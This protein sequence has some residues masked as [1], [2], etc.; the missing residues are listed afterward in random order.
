MQTG[1]SRDSVSRIGSAHPGQAVLLRREPF[2]NGRYSPFA[3]FVDTDQGRGADLGSC[4]PTAPLISL[5]AERGT[6]FI[7][8]VYAEEG[9]GGSGRKEPLLVKDIMYTHIECVFADAPVLE[10]VRKMRGPFVSAL[11]VWENGRLVGIVTD[12]DICC[13]AVGGGRD[14]ASLTVREIMSSEA[15]SCFVDDDCLDAAALMKA[16]GLRRLVALDRNRNVAGIVAV[17]DLARCSADLA[18]TVLEAVASP[19]RRVTGVMM[20]VGEIM[21][22]EVQTVDPDLPLSACAQRMETASIGALPVVKDGR[23]VGLITDRDICCRGV[24]DVRLASPLAA[25][26]IMT[27]NVLSCFA[28]QDCSE[29]AGLMKA[30]RVRRLTVLDR[31]HALVGLLSVDDLAG[32]SHR[33]AGE[34]LGATTAARRSSPASPQ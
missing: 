34:V 27:R 20:P 10:C 24:S 25:R 18:G 30:R 3:A 26:D 12:R 28:D 16:R 14:P 21:S 5:K 4:Q 29:A 9:G 15:A 7:V 1:A 33:H 13:R 22:P 2:W 8:C 11:P 32:W 6:R 23:L 31:G 19:P 17:A